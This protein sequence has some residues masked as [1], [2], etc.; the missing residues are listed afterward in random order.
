M[1]CVLHSALILRLCRQL[2]VQS[3]NRADVK[4]SRNTCPL[5]KSHIHEFM[6]E[7]RGTI[8]LSDAEATVNKEHCFLAF[9]VH[10]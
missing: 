8:C 7:H 5:A 9:F 6:V 2:H 3:A 10:V 1:L 4:A